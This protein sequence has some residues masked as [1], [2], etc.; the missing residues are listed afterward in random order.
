MLLTVFPDHLQVN[1]N[2]PDPEVWLA[3]Y[4]SRNQ[5]GASVAVCQAASFVRLDNTFN[6]S[7][8]TFLSSRERHHCSAFIK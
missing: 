2:D 3:L 8:G 4:V 6:V 7:C 5:S 1:I